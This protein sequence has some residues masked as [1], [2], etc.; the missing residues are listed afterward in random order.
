MTSGFLPSII[1]ASAITARLVPAGAAADDSS[2]GQLEEV[3][4]T[5][6]KKTEVLQKASIAVAALAPEDIARQGITNAVDLQEVVPAVRFVAADQMTVLIRGLG[7]INDNPGVDSSVAYSQDGIYL[8]HPEAL[9]PVLFDLK[10]VEAVLGPQGTLY[11]RNTNGG[12]INFITNDP[13]AEFGGYAK[14]GY[15]NFAAITSDAALN[16]PLGR[17]WAFRIAAGS[18]KHSPYDQDGSNDVNAG[19]GRAKLL[20]KPD[21]NLKVLLTI[22]GAVRHSAGAMYGGSCPPGIVATGCAGVTYVPWS[23]LLPQGHSANNTNTIFGAAA[24]VQYSMAWADLVSLTG[25][26]AYNF[27]ADV[28]PGWYGG[29][30]HFDYTH[31]DQSR[32]FTQELRLSSAADSAL[33]WVTGIYYSREQQPAKV[34]FNYLHSILQD[35]F[36]LPVGYYQRLTTTSSL[37]QSEAAF[38]DV[39]IPFFGNFRFR[40]GLRVTHE[41]KDSTGAVESGIL[42]VPGSPFGPALTNVGS[43]SITKLTWKAGLDYD[44]TPQNLLYVTGSTGFKSGGV[45]NLPAIT[46]L[47]TYGPETITAVELG[48]KNRFLGDRL[49][50][51][52]ALFHYD[53]KNFQTFLFYQPTG[54]PLAGATLFPT[55][56]SQTATF[57][58]GELQATLAITSADRAG[59]QVNVL[60]NKFDRFVVELPFAST[61]DQSGADVPL[62][63]KATYL[64]NYEHTFRIPNGDALTLAANS[65][66]VTSHIVTGNY[67]SNNT[68]TQPSYHRSAA[69]L[70]YQ[71]ASSGWT[72]SAFVRNIENKATINTVAGGYPVL[73]NVNLVN[74][75]IDPPRTYGVS[76]RKDF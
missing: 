37:Y 8:A 63:P 56:N 13:D 53:Y 50:I 36:G 34:Q 76:V 10:R 40:G 75:M 44:I 24:D 72:F 65:Q 16:I 23:G 14:A 67:G 48:S 42:G 71:T 64:V 70:T 15:G 59:F 19:A 31:A 21:D 52:A 69:N 9:T 32:F 17:S 74:V 43:E 61:F 22:D 62:S 49:Q 1:T 46:G 41:T 73:E 66:Y 20:Y 57:E 55:V 29:F 2:T 33:S 7:T 18:E 5:A 68:Y 11:G 35:F 30:D 26:K 38:G 60:H 25:Y 54:G 4:V 6:Q 47:Q 28:S 58:G 12:I 45:N 3:I 27:N 51:N 39:T